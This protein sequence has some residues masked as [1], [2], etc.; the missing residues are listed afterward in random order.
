[1]YERRKVAAL[2]VEQMVK[3]QSSTGQLESV[4]ALVEVLG[5]QYAL[6]SK[7]NAR[8]G[9]LLC[10]AATAVGLA[11]APED[12]LESASRRLL[13]GIVPP[14]LASFTDPDPRVRYYALEALYN[15]AKS[16]RARFLPV[17]PEVF[18]ALFRVCADADQ[19]VQ[20]AASFLDN[21]VKDVVA[22]SGHFDWA[23]FVPRLETCMGVGNPFKQ[24]FL[25]G[26]LSL[27]DSLPEVDLAAHLPSLLPGL[28]LLLGEDTPEIR[29]AALRLV[30]DM[31]SDLLSG[32]RSADVAAVAQVLAQTLIADRLQETQ[33]G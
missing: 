18:D 24:Q 25:L 21:L 12:A 27:L 30:R 3:S 5:S 17:F 16:L 20:T 22:E 13:P 7:L 11:A 29:V 26:W 32:A 31:E 9:G 19:S 2:E 4:E 23:S 33:G 8:K 6:S 1:L 28:L 14:I 10:L 15:V